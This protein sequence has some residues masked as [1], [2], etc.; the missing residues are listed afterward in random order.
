MAGLRQLF[1]GSSPKVQVFLPKDLPLSLEVVLVEGGGRLDLGGMWL[2][3]VDLQL[4]QGG[5]QVDVDDPLRQPAERIS[6]Y[7][8]MGGM[9]IS[10]LGNASPRRLEVDFS[11]G[12]MELDLR[13]QWL[14][15]SDIDIQSSIGGAILR[16]PRDVTIEGLDTGR[17]RPPEEA[18]IALPT[19]RF[20]TTISMGELEII[21]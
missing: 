5:F 20:T 7:C 15:D 9:E 1:G 12:G 6:L 21:P 19:L 3:E 8:S 14:N 11:M 16:L 10:R 18:E 17:F 4:T 13:G 2:T